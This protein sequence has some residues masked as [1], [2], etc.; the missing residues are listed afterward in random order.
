MYARAEFRED[1][2]ERLA[3]LI[4]AHPFAVLAANGEN[5]PVAA[6][7]PLVAEQDESGGPAVLVGHLARANPFW[8]SVQDGGPVLA[9]FSG[10]DAYVSPSF[11][12]SK[13]EH[14]RVAPTWNYMRVEAR[15]R[16]HLQTAPGAAL[17]AIRALT[18]AMEAPRAD[19]WSVDDAPSDYVAGLSRGVVGF[20]IA[21]E[22]LTGVWKLSQNQAPADW[23][24]AVSGLAASSVPQERAT[25][26]AMAFERE[27]I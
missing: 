4:A 21:V 10:V 24:G 5:G 1:R 7:V 27:S 13:Q 18:D 6:H 19:P 22:S 15:G 8:T 3:A 14:G 23:A 9:V 20:R 11:Y 25:A 12:P 26:A 2:P 16:L 17:P